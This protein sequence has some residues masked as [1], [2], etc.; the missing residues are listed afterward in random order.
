MYGTLVGNV[1]RD[2]IVALSRAYRQKDGHEAFEQ[3]GDAET[4][5]VAL[6]PRAGVSV[7]PDR[8]PLG[9]NLGRWREI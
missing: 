9:S 5:D 7:G 3:P 8:V 1:S 2:V 4:L 6:T